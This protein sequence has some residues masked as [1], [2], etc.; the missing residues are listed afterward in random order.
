MESS[1]PEKEQITK[2]ARGKQQT[3]T[4]DLLTEVGVT[5]V[6]KLKIVHNGLHWLPNASHNKGVLV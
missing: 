2:G 3:R 5:Q 1:R 4:L 6:I